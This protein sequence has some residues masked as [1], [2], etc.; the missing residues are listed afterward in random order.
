MGATGAGV[1]GARVPNEWVWLPAWGRQGR[2]GPG[3]RRASVRVG[4]VG[5]SVAVGAR[6]PWGAP[7]GVDVGSASGAVGVAGRSVAVGARHGH[8]LHW[9]SR[10]DGRRAWQEWGSQLA[11]R[12]SRWGLGGGGLGGAGRDGSGTAAG[13]E[14]TRVGIEAEIG[15]VD[16]EGTTVWRPV[17]V[18]NARNRTPVCRSYRG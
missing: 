11:P 16:L 4:V 18:R 13:L 3:S 10:R 12:P 8:R 17:D 5:R 14:T 2:G 1:A 7:G 9:C 6:W 15:P